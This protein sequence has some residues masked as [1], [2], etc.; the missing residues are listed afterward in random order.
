MAYDGSWD[1]YGLDCAPKGA[2]K[3]ASH[4]PAP[5]TLDLEKVLEERLRQEGRL[6]IVKAASTFTIDG[7]I[8]SDDVRD[9]AV[10]VEKMGA[11]V[12]AREQADKALVGRFERAA[13][14]LL[15]RS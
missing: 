2:E 12:D 3:T 1:V 4:E 5:E 13:R 6:E 14:M 7:P 8:G 11:A 10:T 15:E 9:L